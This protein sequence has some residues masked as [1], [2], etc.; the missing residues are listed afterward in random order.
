MRKLSYRPLIS[1][2][3]F[4]FSKQPMLVRGFAFI[5]ILLLFCNLDWHYQPNK[6][7]WLPPITRWLILCTVL[8]SSWLS[9]QP[10]WL[11]LP[12][13]PVACPQVSLGHLFDAKFQAKFWADS[14]SLREGMDVA[15]WTPLDFHSIVSDGSPRG[16]ESIL[17]W[18]VFRNFLL[19]SFAPLTN[20]CGVGDQEEIIFSPKIVITSNRFIDSIDI[21]RYH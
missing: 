7:K 17:T 10:D 8:V 16:L 1:C 5:V 12:H 2:S 20:F 14:D 3:Y 19:G 15:P 9:H 18:W 13:L 11:V 6:V 4:L 21:N